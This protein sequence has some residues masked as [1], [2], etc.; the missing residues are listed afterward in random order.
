MESC[1]VLAEQEAGEAEQSNRRRG[2]ESPAI[3]L[4]P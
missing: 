4:P 3:G 1:G 2:A